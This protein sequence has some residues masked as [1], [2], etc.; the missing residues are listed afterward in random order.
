MS[1]VRRVPP[2][3]AGR[4]W[5]QHRLAV[6]QRGADL[7]DQKLRILR[8]ERQRLALLTERTRAGWERASAEA[9][10][11]LLRSGLLGGQ[12][13]TLLAGT[14]PPAEVRVSWR[15]SMGARYPD[16]AVCLLP[17]TDPA[18]PPPGNAALVFARDA[19]RRALEAAVTHAAA[20]AA[21]RVVAAEEAATR[22][23]LR[24]IEDRWVP[25]LRQSLAEL[26]LGLEEQEHAEGLRR[27]WAAARQPARTD[28]QHEEV[29]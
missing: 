10:A 13:A 6:A 2:G 17:D 25:R 20:E 3:R 16:E 22:R 7:L 28:A 5:L 8:G 18:A 9:D 4:L 14:G 1:T 27:R 21:A 19:H 12:R 29:R 24:A 23:R 11:W 15:T 26:Q